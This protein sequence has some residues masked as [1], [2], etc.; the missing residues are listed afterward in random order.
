M[1]SWKMITAQHVVNDL[2]IEVL[3]PNRHQLEYRAAQG[4]V[5]INADPIIAPDGAPDG[6]QL[7]LSADLRWQ[8][9]GAPVIGEERRLMALDLI[10]AAAPLRTK[11]E[12]V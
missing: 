9:S 6:S 7:D 1:T 11:F 8:P 4:A 5:R 3:F 2:G 10:E 12:L